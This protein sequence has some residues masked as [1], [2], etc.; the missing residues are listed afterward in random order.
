VIR[1]TIAIAFRSNH[2]NKEKNERAYLQWIQKWGGD[3]R[4][5]GPGDPHPLKGADGLVLTGGEDIAPERYGEKNWGCKKINLARDEFELKILQNAFRRNLP[6][7]GICRG[8]QVLAVALGGTLVQH[9]PKDLS[10]GNNRLPNVAHWDPKGK[11]QIHWMSIQQGTRLS[12]IIGKKR[13]MV[14]SHHHQGVRTVPPSVIISARS[15]D[16]V[17]EAIEVPE[18]RFVIGI[19]WHPERWEK[20]S[21]KAIV[22]AFIKECRKSHNKQ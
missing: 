20:P 5:I 4:M 11:D 15:K 3:F 17:I 16:E 7:L 18:K 10:S 14:N 19:H 13:I 6:V 8:I 2:P 21:S 22:R 9:L 1:P 12:R